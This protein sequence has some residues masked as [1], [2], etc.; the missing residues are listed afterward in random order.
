MD[1]FKRKTLWPTLHSSVSIIWCSKNCSNP[2]EFFTWNFYFITLILWISQSEKPLKNILH[3]VIMKYFL[4]WTWSFYQPSSS[5][6]TC[7]WPFRI[8]LPPNPP[9]PPE[10]KPDISLPKKSGTSCP[11]S[12]RILVK[13]PATPESLPLKLK[14]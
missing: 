1:F 13:S 8:S 14:F 6:V 4:F 2:F 10:A 12:D 9:P 7:S 3:K 11:A 5:F